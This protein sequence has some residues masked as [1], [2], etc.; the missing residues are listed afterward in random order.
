VLLAARNLCTFFYFC[1]IQQSVTFHY[2]EIFFLKDSS[3]GD[4]RIYKAPARLQKHTIY[5][6]AQIHQQLNSQAFKQQNTTMQKVTQM[7]CLTVLLVLVATSYMAQATAIKDV[8]GKGF[9]NHLINK[10]QSCLGLLAPGAYCTSGYQ[11][12]TS[13][14]QRGVCACG[15]QCNNLRECCSNYCCARYGSRCHTRDST[16]CGG[17]SL[18]FCYNECFH[19]YGHREGYYRS[20]Y[21]R[22][23]CYVEYHQCV[24]AVRTG[25]RASNAGPACRVWLSSLWY[26]VFMIKIIRF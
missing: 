13:N 4:R 25:V 16:C 20:G 18:K 17:T 10:S 14:C 26:V 11:C 9:H 15:D 22:S 21:Y 24:R 8:D 2:S 19:G 3:H 7:L 12:C 6:L 1:A 23:G 5:I